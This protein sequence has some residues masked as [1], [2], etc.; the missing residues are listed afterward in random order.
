MAHQTLRPPA[1]AGLFYPGT[2]AEVD[3]QARALLDHAAQ[4]LATVTPAPDPKALV[5]PHAGWR[6]SGDLA[7]LGWQT[8]AHRRST[9]TRVVVLGPTHRVAIRGVALPGTDRFATPLGTLAVPT[10]EVL[11]LTAGLPTPVTVDEATHAQEHAIEVQVPFIQEVLGEVELVPLNAGLVD[12][13]AL[14]DVIE[15]LWG[16]PETVIAVSS[17]LSHYLP[18]AMARALD[19]DTI[20]RIRACESVDHERACGATPL[21]GLLEVCRRRGMSPRLLGTHTSGDAAGDHD[22]VVGYAAFSI[23]EEA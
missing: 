10:D 19:D 20:A 22:R 1:V 7:A 4:V 3:T 2:R 23:D 8:L 12:E 9:I 21:G 18:D 11:D 14:A 17:D 6:Y 15:A 16:G 13:S 5:V